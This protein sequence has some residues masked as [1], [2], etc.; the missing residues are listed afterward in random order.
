MNPATQGLNWLKE[1]S[2]FLLPIAGLITG[3][4]AVLA[5]F[6]GNLGVSGNVTASVVAAVGFGTTE[7]S[8]FVDSRSFTDIQ[9]A[10]ASTSVLAV[11][12]ALDQAAIDATPVVKPVP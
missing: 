11:G 9:T 5:L 10:A 12:A 8:K 2:H 6:L 7:L 4:G 1:L 3:S